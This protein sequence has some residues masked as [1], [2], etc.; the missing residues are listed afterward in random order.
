M[1]PLQLDLSLCLLPCMGLLGCA[2]LVEAPELA[3]A[4]P[5]RADPFPEVDEWLEA[6]AER[7]PLSMG[8]A[9]MRSAKLE[10]AAGNYDAVEVAV[11]YALD[12]DIEL[13]ELHLTRSE[14]AF[15][16]GEFTSAES[17]LDKYAREVRYEL[18]DE[19]RTRF[20]ARIDNR[21]LDIRER[22][23]ELG[24][25]TCEL[26]LEQ[27]AQ[28]L[29]SH[30]NYLSVFNEL[31]ARMSSRS[32]LEIPTS[33]RRAE[34]LLCDGTCTQELTLVRLDGEEDAIIGLL[35]RD[36]S[37]LR[38]VPELLH[39][40]LNDECDEDTHTAIERHGSQLRVRVFSEY[41]GEPEP[42]E[43]P[44]VEDWRLGIEAELGKIQAKV[45]AAG[46]SA[47]S[48]YY[49][50][51]GYGSSGYGSSGYASSG[52]GSSGY[53]SSGCGGGYDYDYG[54]YDEYYGYC[55]PLRRIQRDTFIDLARGEV[56]LDIVRTGSAEAGLGRVESSPGTVHVQ[57]CDVE[58]RLELSWTGT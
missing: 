25:E 18:E 37:G 32:G 1:R 40:E 3:P 57:A 26:Q 14:A 39:P 20:E 52:Y 31:S 33:E 11:T 29:S 36:E 15:A 48:Y 44:P 22:A 23:F 51:S 35:V 16:R 21:R 45:A 12:H 9:A 58:Q 7:E 55:E 8:E 17:A 4:D 47:N 43:E 30:D 41:K 24:S 34:L 50:S 56:V 54:Y 10:L 2:T 27:G 49:G 28:P 19:E 42:Y 5:L 38:L 13:A 53:Y 46:I 6:S